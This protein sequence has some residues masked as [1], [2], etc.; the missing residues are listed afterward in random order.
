MDKRKIR[1]LSIFDD[2]DTSNEPDPYQDDDG[3]YGSDKDFDPQGSTSGS[4]SSYSKNYRQKS[5]KTTKGQSNLVGISTRKPESNVTSD[6]SS[7][8]DDT[9]SV[10]SDHSL[11]PANTPSPPRTPTTTSRFQ[12]EV[13]GYESN[14]SEEIFPL[15]KRLKLVKSPITTVPT[16]N[17]GPNEVIEEGHI[18]LE[19]EI[20]ENLVQTSPRGT[21]QDILSSHNISQNETVGLSTLSLISNVLAENLD[22]TG[23]F[24]SLDILPPLFDE[25]QDEILQEEQI[26]SG[27]PSNALDTPNPRTSTTEDWSETTAPIPDFNFDAGAVGVKFT[28]DNNTTVFEV[29]NRLFPPLILDYLVEC[30]NAYGTSM[31]QTNRPKTR[32]SRSYTF[33]LTDKNEM[34]KFLGLCLLGAQVNIPQKRK[35]FTL[36][37]CLYYHPVFVSTMSG[38]RYEQ[39]LRC[40]CTGPLGAKGKNKITEFMDAITRNFRA[41]YSP[42]KELSLDESLL[43]FRGRLSFRQYIKSKKA[44]YGIKFYELTEANGYVLNILMY[45]GKDDSTDL[46][47][48]KKT[49]K[50]VMK[51]MRPYVL[52]GH[53]LFMDNYYNSY[54]L[55]QKLLDLKTH[56][57]GTLRKSRKENPKN[58]MNKKIKKGEHVW[59]RKNNVYVSKWVDKRAVTMITTK[60]HP[61]MINVANKR[62]QLK[63]K[64]IEVVSYNAFMSGIDRADQMVSYY[65][66]PRKCLRW[67]K[68]VFFHLLDL[69]VWNSFYLY[70]KY[71]MN[72]SKKYEFL[73][74]REDLIRTLIGISLSQRPELLLKHSKNDNRRVDRTAHPRPSPTQPENGSGGHWPEKI[75]LP[76]GSKKTT[77][78]LKCKMCAKNK[79][80]KETGLR[81]KGC[82]DKPALCALCFEEWHETDNVTSS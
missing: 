51:L 10:E 57:V 69:T 82:K 47:Q 39:L 81:C 65:S 33:K 73:H 62:G 38:R 32:H 42:E 78:Y 1:P 16:V 9:K 3:E 31:C 25:P 64:P 12:E 14:S 76:P 5:T 48:G 60:D 49:D 52:K 77:N 43:L 61:K 55:S 21:T 28:I 79:R 8:E 20:I 40:L 22:N 74:F 30:T 23:E 36:S 4:E 67:Y 50:T 54:G 34:L 58:V 56:T 46:E 27:Q 15:A 7:D 37:D 80:R 29:F 59:V 70:R 26:G 19:P 44:K 24:R 53:E 66:S 18:P 35:L 2:S 72:N 17:Q 13:A 68:K 45:T 41:C 6:P 75:P 11:C 71:K 63:R